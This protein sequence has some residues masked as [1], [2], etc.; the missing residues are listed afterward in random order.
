MA[1]PRTRT[2]TEIKHMAQECLMD[3]VAKA[4]GY[5][6]PTEYGDVMTPEEE[7]E[8]RTVLKVQADRVAKLLGYGESWSS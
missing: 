8:F 1:T 7:E 2:R 3:H 6:N 5:Y 4:L